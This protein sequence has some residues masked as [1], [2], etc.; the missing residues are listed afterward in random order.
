MRSE[1]DQMPDLPPIDGF[2][3]EIATA[4]E[5]PSFAIAMCTMRFPESGPALREVLRRAADGESLTEEDETL[6]FRG[7]YILGGR[8]DPQSFDPLMRLL[9]RP[10]EQVDRLL[11]LA[12][13]EALARIVV[14]V[15]DG[16]SDALFAAIADRR[17]DEF[18]REA[19]L[20]AA[21]FLAWE[22]R[23][24]PVQ[25]VSF[26]KLFHDER[27]ADD[28]DMAWVAW[29]NAIAL[30]DLRPLKLLADF[31][32]HLRMSLYRRSHAPSL[33]PVSFNNLA[34]TDYARAY[35]QLIQCAAT[36]HVRLVVGNFSMA[37]NERS[38]ADVIEFYRAGFPS[39]HWDIRANMAHSLLVGQ[40][41]G[42]HPEVCLVDTHPSLDGE[43]EA[44][45]HAV[46][47]HQHRARSANAVFAADMRPGQSERVA[48]KIGQQQT[49]LDVRNLVSR[50]IHRHRY[51]HAHRIILSLPTLCAWPAW[52]VRP[53]DVS[54]IRRRRAGRC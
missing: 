19:L 43:H 50:S 42:L 47:I 7:L 20:G 2:L 21:T 4:E 24:D 6:L 5:L 34:D 27:L 16:N 31:E 25:M 48:Q 12:V 8:R 10:P 29:L 35:E 22:G 9:H 53:A 46:A 23:I 37:V 49:R 38:D 32:H 26:L 36:N 15:F 41:A 30:L 44:G 40:A 17:L 18:V 39:V 52:P 3:T 54:C 28:A 13:T 11:G 14:G 33:F 45:P 51:V 1:F